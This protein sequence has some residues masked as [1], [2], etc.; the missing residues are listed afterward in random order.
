MYLVSRYFPKDHTANC[1][2]QQFCEIVLEYNMLDTNQKHYCV[3]DNAKIM[4]A[5]IGSEINISDAIVVVKY[6]KKNNTVCTFVIVVFTSCT[7][8]CFYFY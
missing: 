3:I 1:I 4:V 7:W 2:S 8:G 6:T 5:A